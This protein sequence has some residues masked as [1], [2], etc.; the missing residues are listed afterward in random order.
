VRG[1]RKYLTK[2]A[3]LLRQNSSYVERKMWYLLRKNI[4]E[5]KF[6]RQQPIGRCIQINMDILLSIIGNKYQNI[7]NLFG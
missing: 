2:Y 5:R 3:R 1:M 4:P 6:R 7:T